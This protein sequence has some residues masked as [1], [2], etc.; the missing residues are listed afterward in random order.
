MNTTEPIEIQICTDCLMVAANGEC[1]LDAEDDPFW[2]SDMD[3]WIVSPGHL[4]TI[5]E[6]GYDV[7]N[8]YADCPFDEGSF[9]WTPCDVCRRPLGG[10]RYPASMFQI[11][12]PA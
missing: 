2:P 10:D 9:S 6:C 4:H 8:G 12:V 7:Y 3:G 5:E 11:E 1:E